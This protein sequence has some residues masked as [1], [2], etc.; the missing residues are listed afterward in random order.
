MVAVAYMLTQVALAKTLNI[1][2]ER[3]ESIL[4][5][6]LAQLKM[7]II[8]CLTATHAVTYVSNTATFSVRPHLQLQLFWLLTNPMW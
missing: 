1:A 7:N 3:I 5:A 2:T 6:C 8:L 4:C